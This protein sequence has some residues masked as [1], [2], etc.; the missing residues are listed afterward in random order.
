MD[1]GKV[2]LIQRRRYEDVE[3][4]GEGGLKFCVC[5]RGASKNR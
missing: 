2:H 5:V 3:R 4:G 1:K